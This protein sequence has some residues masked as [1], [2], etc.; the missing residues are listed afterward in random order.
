[1]CGV[2]PTFAQI[3]VTLQHL[4][5]DF[6]SFRKYYSLFV[7][8]A[9]DSTGTRRADTLGHDRATFGRSRGLVPA[10]CPVWLGFADL[11]FHADRITG[12]HRDHHVVDV[13]AVAGI[14]QRQG[15][16]PEDYLRQQPQ[17]IDDGG[18]PLCTRK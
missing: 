6:D 1:M 10:Q 8:R 7:R 18:K 16:R 12:S 13:D 2:P 9:N 4:F 5:I 17:T 15:V 11:R 14:E 3:C